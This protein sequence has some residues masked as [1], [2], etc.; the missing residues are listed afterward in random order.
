M[1]RSLARCA[2][3]LTSARVGRRSASR[4]VSRTQLLASR[5][6][7]VGM[8]FNIGGLL[9]GSSWTIAHVLAAHAQQKGE[10]GF[11]PPLEP[12][13]DSAGSTG[14]GGLK[15]CPPSIRPPPPSEPPIRKCDH[16]LLR[17]T[18]RDL[19]SW[20]REYGQCPCRH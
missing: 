8:S 3:A 6:A 10:A 9:E 4:S 15:L 5:K 19:R 20:R 7:G 14:P 16:C 18:R 12:F 13:F 17:E 1:R 11:P 2:I